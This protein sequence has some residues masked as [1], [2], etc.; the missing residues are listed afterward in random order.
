[1]SVEAGFVHFLSAL[2]HHRG[3]GGRQAVPTPTE[4]AGAHEVF[5]VATVNALLEGV[6]D[7]E[8]TYGE[9]RRHG[10]FGLGTFNALDGE[11]AA[12]D[13][14]FYQVKADGRVYPVQDAQ[15]TPFAVVQWFE[16]DLEL[17]LDGADDMAALQR[18]FDGVLGSHNVFCAL[19][20]DGRFAHVRTRS[21][22]AQARPYRPLVEV[23]RDQPEFE[24]T[25]VEGTL[26]GFR[27]PDYAAG[28]N[29]PGYHLHFL[30]A[31]RAAGGHV[32]E[33]RLVGGLAHADCTSGFHLELPHGGDF[34]A[35]DLAADRR[36]ELDQA[37]R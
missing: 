30:T 2:R 18:T 17:R 19:R 25:D 28:L 33:L 27:F 34:L 7:G 12:C 4:H 37:E 13:G 11:M 5:Q 23:T 36:A 26:I 9:L 21:V 22:P 14:A 16:P 35:A 24:L 10:D 1:V 31:D 8:L 15:R 32:L 20:V 3:A 6:Y 29:V